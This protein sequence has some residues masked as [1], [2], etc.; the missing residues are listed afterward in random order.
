[1]AEKR[2][3]EFKDFKLTVERIGE[4]RYSVLFRGALSYDY[5]GTPVLEG[6][7]KTIEGDFKFLFYPRSSLKEK[8]NLFELTFPTA[9][10]EKKF[11]SWLEKVKKQ[12]G[13]I[14]G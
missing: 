5:G 1:M 6:E 2:T 7:R 10:K 8:N 13:G 3:I 9:E 11:S 14:E 12:Y 4:G